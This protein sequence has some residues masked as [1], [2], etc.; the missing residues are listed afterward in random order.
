MT[1]HA[2]KFIPAEKVAGYVTAPT[3][4]GRMSLTLTLMI[5]LISA[6]SIPPSSPPPSRRSQPLALTPKPCGSHLSIADKWL[7]R[8]K[9]G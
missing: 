6:R 7:S 8:P 3:E 2:N 1:N 9:A 4:R 5:S